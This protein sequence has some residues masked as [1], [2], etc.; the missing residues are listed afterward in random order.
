M[1]QLYP[2]YAYKRVGYADTAE[3]AEQ[4]VADMRRE[5]TP[6]D[7]IEDYVVGDPVSDPTEFCDGDAVVG[8]LHDGVHTPPDR[9]THPGRGVNS[10]PS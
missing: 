3:G 10:F 9:Y 6:A 8:S 2:V 1:A 5:L 7:A 4:M